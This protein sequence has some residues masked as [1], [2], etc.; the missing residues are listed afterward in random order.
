MNQKLFY[1]SLAGILLFSVMT[2][3]SLL[4]QLP[5]WLLLLLSTTPAL[6]VIILLVASRSRDKQSAEA[7]R[8]KEAIARMLGNYMATSNGAFDVVSEQFSSLRR[9]LNQAK[10]ILHSAT[11][12]LA[13]SFTGLDNE[14]E[15]QRQRLQVL[16]EE[17]YNVARG[18]QYKEQTEGINRFSTQSQ[19]IVTNYISTLSEMKNN[20]SAIVD[21]FSEMT[22]QVNSV[23]SLLND[24]NDITSQTDL[25]ALNAAIEAARAG[26]A[27]RGFAVVADEVRNLSRRTNQFSDQIRDLIL[28]TQSTMERVSVNIQE[29]AEADMSNAL[30]AQDQVGNMWEEMRALNKGATTQAETINELSDSI[31]QHVNTGILSLQFEDIAV[32]LVDHIAQRSE[33]I[34]AFING[35]IALHFEQSDFEQQI[36]HFQTRLSDLEKIINNG[37]QGFAQLDQNKAVAQQNVE[38]GSVDLF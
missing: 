2:T 3:V 21:N 14:T 27:G 26:D 36:E 33:Q 23:V 29:M 17:L 11:E 37:K 5:D 9:E 6:I 19:E 13:G 16:V 30:E 12:K 32:Q 31:R 34:E 4:A 22:G 8:K 20:S 24:V 1:G 15:D 18:N 7:E 28:Q 38:S 25:L 35:L 10:D